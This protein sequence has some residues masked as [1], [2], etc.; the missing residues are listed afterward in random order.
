MA[1]RRTQIKR[2]KSQMKRS[3][4]KK[5][6][7]TKPLKRTPLKRKSSLNSSKTK[8]K[9]V[10]KSEQ[11]QLAIDTLKC[12]KSIPRKYRYKS[13]NSLIKDKA[14]AILSDYVRCRDTILYRECVATGNRIENWR[15]MQA[16]HYETM[17]GHGAL[18]GFSELNIHA[19]SANSNRQSSMADGAKYKETLIKRYGKWIIDEINELKQSTVKADDFFFIIKIDYITELFIELVEEHPNFDYPKYIKTI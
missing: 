9:R 2:G 6:K 13:K 1:L 7:T 18:L 15:D 17:G 5:K 4:F 8:P 3:G 16:G 10:T 11:V 19:Q 12:F 14:W